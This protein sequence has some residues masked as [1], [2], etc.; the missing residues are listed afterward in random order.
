M[1]GIPCPFLPPSLP[2][3]TL[4]DANANAVLIKTVLNSYV[5]IGDILGGHHKSTSGRM[6]REQTDEC[7]IAG[8]AQAAL[9]GPNYGGGSRKTPNIAFFGRLF[10]PKFL[11]S[12]KGGKGR[13]VACG[14]SVRP[15]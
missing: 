7:L 3:C 8:A 15:R 2:A 11:R 5:D 6:A 14:A 1:R 13:G 12:G 9:E 10:G 4:L